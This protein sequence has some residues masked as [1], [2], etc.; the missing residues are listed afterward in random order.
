MLQLLLV[1]WVNASVSGAG[2]IVVDYKAK[3][4]GK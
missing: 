4:V 2:E 1:V 3:T